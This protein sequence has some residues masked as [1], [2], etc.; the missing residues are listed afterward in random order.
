MESNKVVLEEEEEQLSSSEKRR[1]LGFFLA[2]YILIFV[3]WIFM[4][5]HG[6][7]FSYPQRMGLLQI[8]GALIMVVVFMNN[9]TN[10]A[11]LYGIKF[12]PYGDFTSNIAAIVTFVNNFLIYMIKSVYIII[13]VFIVFNLI[14]HSV[15]LHKI[16]NILEAITSYTTFYH[17][18]K[19]RWVPLMF[20]VV[21]IP[22]F[23]I[24]LF[25]VIGFIITHLKLLLGLTVTNH[26]VKKPKEDPGSVI[27]WYN[28]GYEI[29][30]PIYDLMNIK[31]TSIRDF[32]KSILVIGSLLSIIVGTVAVVRKPREGFDE[33]TV[34]SYMDNQMAI[35]WVIVVILII[36]LLLDL[37]TKTL[38]QILENR[39]EDQI[40]GDTDW[41]TFK[42]G[43]TTKTIKDAFKLVATY[44]NAILDQSAVDQMSAML[45]DSNGN[46]SGN[47]DKGTGGEDKGSEEKGGE[48]KKGDKKVSSELRARIGE[49]TRKKCWDNVVKKDKEGDLKDAYKMIEDIKNHEKEKESLEK[50]KKKLDDKANNA[51]N[52]EK[53]KLNSQVKDKDEEIKKK[54]EEISQIQK[55]VEKILDQIEAAITEAKN[56]ENK[57]KC[58]GLLEKKG[59]ELKGKAEE[60]G[61]NVKKGVDNAVNSVKGKLG[62]GEKKE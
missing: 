24:L 9:K 23:V 31:I 11:E 29:Y 33:D 10:I 28:F 62:I 54:D 30:R 59:K 41:K 46:S 7:A 19:D 26:F 48:G 34:I 22:L 20:I 27:Q 49:L 50:E 1:L 55:E 44:I 43:F 57:G 37:K 35:R 58:D 52:E 61:K 51:Q 39:P 47:D 53:G 21:G 42:K 15:E 40:K 16:E 3:I 60:I 6:F 4:F 18:I 45:G 14:G 8:I 38:P 36:Q 56:D 25:H 17:S 5:L 2:K 12:N 13:G 32:G